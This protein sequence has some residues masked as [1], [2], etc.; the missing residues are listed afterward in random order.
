MNVASQI[1]LNKQLKGSLTKLMFLSGVLLI[2]NLFLTATIYRQDLR[3]VLVPTHLNKELIVTIGSVSEEYLELITRD[4]IGLILNLTPENYEYAESSIL[5]HTHPSTYGVLQHELAELA[6][7][8]KTRNVS[9]YF[10]MTDMVVDKQKLTVDVTG[11][12]QTN[13]GLKAISRELRRYRIIYDFTGGRLMLKE[14]YEVKDES[15]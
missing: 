14:F 15:L 7:D 9:I 5:K 1:Q 12:L 3:V 4:Y 10:S 2:S 6:R 13:L 8:I 11:H